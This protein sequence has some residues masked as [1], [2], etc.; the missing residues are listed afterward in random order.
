MTRGSQGE[1]QRT[2][3]EL[4]EIKS[5]PMY[6]GNDKK[7]EEEVKKQVGEIKSL[8]T[9]LLEAQQ[10]NQKLKGGIFGMSCEPSGLL[11]ESYNA[12]YDSSVDEGMLT[13]R[14]EE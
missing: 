8:K 11:I 5:A 1:E 9:Q 2:D 4:E 12:E 7:L 3:P 14:P 13:G 6:Y 10:G